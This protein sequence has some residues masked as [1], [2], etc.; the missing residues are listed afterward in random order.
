MKSL[1]YRHISTLQNAH[2]HPFASTKLATLVRYRSRAHV[3]DTAPK[4]PLFK[5]EYGIRQCWPVIEGPS[6]G[7]CRRE[8]HR[9]FD[10]R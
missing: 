3:A 7:F 1:Q 9:E 2:L 4:V 5:S 6:A 10:I 8:M